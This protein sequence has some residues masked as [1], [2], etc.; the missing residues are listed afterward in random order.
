LRI[1]VCVNHTDNDRVG[2][3]HA[4][5]GAAGDGAVIGSPAPELGA[6]LIGAET[7]GAGR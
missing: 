3:R 2:D 5:G 7:V 1:A 6:V 4:S